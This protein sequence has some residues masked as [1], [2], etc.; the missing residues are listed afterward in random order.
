LTL[1]NLAVGMMAQRMSG[2]CDRPRDARRGKPR[3]RRL[4]FR[5]WRLEDVEHA[6][7]LWGDPRVTGLIDARGWLERAQVEERLRL[8]IALERRC[9]FQYWP[10]FLRETGEFVGCA[11]LRPR[12]LER[13][14]YEVGFHLCA[15]FW[16]RGLASEAALAV[17]AFAFGRLGATALF[18]GHHPHNR[19]SERV[20]Y[21]LGFRHTHDEHYPPT[22]LM[23]PSY[24]LPRSMS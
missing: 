14:V 19:A 22:G 12:N 23:H 18:A 16:G 13:G 3:S 10:M 15:R 6:I 8:E 4:L 20:L 7:E 1:E 24:L 21:K 11:G 2:E 5:S 9:G 17:M